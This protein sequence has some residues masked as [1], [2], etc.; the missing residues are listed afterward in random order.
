MRTLEKCRK[1]SP[2]FYISFSNALHVLSQCNTRLWLLYLLKKK[3]KNIYIYI[4]IYVYM[5]TE[6]T[7]IRIDKWSI[8]YVNRYPTS[9][10]CQS[11]HNCTA[12]TPRAVSLASSQKNREYLVLL[13]LITCFG[14]MFS[15]T[16]YFFYVI[17]K[18][19]QMVACTAT[20]TREDRR[21]RTNIV[22]VELGASKH[23]LE[24]KANKC[25]KVKN[26]K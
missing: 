6:V 11:S 24:K 14:K 2:V 12:E 8:E 15:R 3:K 10:K 16:D 4:Y 1:Y 17:F 7:S 22:V 19:P 26:C 9:G 25:F 18:C 20:K 5:S 23:I 13:I 21:K